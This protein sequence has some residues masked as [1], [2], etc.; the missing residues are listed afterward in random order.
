MWVIASSAA[1]RTAIMTNK[2]KEINVYH[3]DFNIVKSNKYYGVA[4]AQY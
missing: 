1:R 3:T 2:S 4:D